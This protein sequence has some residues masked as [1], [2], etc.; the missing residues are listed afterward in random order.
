MKSPWKNFRQFRYLQHLLFFSRQF[1]MIFQRP[2]PCR[3]L[4]I[5]LRTVLKVWCR[6]QRAPVNTSNWLDP[7]KEWYHIEMTSYWNLDE[8]FLFCYLGS[9][10][11]LDVFPGSNTFVSATFEGSMASSWEQS[12]VAAEYKGDGLSEGRP[13]KWFKKLPY[14]PDLESFYTRVSINLQEWVGKRGINISSQVAY[15]HPKHPKLS[16]LPIRSLR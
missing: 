4:Y 8:T 7:K 5:N 12:N 10:A 3:I 15:D 11:D 16:V 13:Q 1:W 2:V 9:A 14:W 6:M